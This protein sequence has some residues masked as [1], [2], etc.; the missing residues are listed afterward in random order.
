[1]KIDMS[2]PILPRLPSPLPINKFEASI[3]DIRSLEHDT[4]NLASTAKALRS[5]SAV[6]PGWKAFE[7]DPIL[8]LLRVVQLDSRAFFDSLEWALDEIGQ[9]SLDEYLMSRRLGAWRKLMSDFEMAVPA[10][11]KSLHDFTT[12]VFADGMKPELPKEIRIIIESVDADIIRIESRLAAAYTTLRADTQ[13]F[14]SRR[15][16][17]ETKTVT[18]LT[19]LAFLFIPLSFTASLFSMSIQELDTSVPVWTF[20]A[21]S[22]GMAALAYG[23]RLMLT[24]EYLAKSLHGAFERFRAQRGLPRGANAPIFTIALFTLREIWQNG[25]AKV[26][27]K[28]LMVLFGGSLIVVPIAFAWTSTSLDVGFQAAVSLFLVLSSLGLAFCFSDAAGGEY[29]TAWARGS[30]ESDDGSGSV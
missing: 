23:V 3:D 7:A 9:D 2:V 22:L 14:E 18:K 24:S 17:T 30:D 4:R 29:M 25:A 6:V 12:F 26:L 21:T 20:I 8:G 15:S 16:I 5:Q 10:I 11:G 28:A 1:M 27:A 13:S 19:E